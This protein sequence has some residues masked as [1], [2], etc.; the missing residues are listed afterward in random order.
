MDIYVGNLS[1][2]TTDADLKS[3]FEA[4]G[5]VESARVVT[6]HRSGRSQG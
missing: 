1:Y 4:Y 2:K 6:E 3:L 5:E